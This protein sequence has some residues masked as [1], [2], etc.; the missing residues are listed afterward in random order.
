MTPFLDQKLLGLFQEKLSSLRPLF[1]KF[2]LCLTSDNSTSPNI[3][4]YGCMGS[5][6]PQIWGASS[7]PL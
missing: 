5:P 4:V 7:S 6:S 1:S 2:V 3:G